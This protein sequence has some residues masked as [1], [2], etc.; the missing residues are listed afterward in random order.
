M[1]CDAPYEGGGQMGTG[2]WQE[3][4]RAYCN[5]VY[6]VLIPFF[7]GRYD[8]ALDAPSVKRNWGVFGE[9]VMKYQPPNGNGDAI[10]IREDVDWTQHRIGRS[11]AH[12]LGHAAIHQNADMDAL[13]TDDTYDPV[14]LSAVKEGVCERFREDGLRE[15]SR[16]AREQGDT[17][18]AWRYQYQRFRHGAL[19]QFNDAVFSFEKPQ[20]RLGRAL[21]DET[22][23]EDMTAVIKQPDAVYDEIV[24]LAEQQSYR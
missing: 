20:Y 3:A 8:I 23:E 16:S 14:L 24:Q 7:E 21:M 2:E 18:S 6:D 15:L 10:K 11:I 9:P 17:A 22:S 13:E 5:N 4:Y 1:E 12:E 19:T